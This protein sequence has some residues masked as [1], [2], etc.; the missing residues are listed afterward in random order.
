VLIFACATRLGFG[1]PQITSFDFWQ[2][3]VF[4]KFIGTH[5]EYDAIDTLT[6]ARF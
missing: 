2:Q 6:V 5:A 4:V 1:G 3:I